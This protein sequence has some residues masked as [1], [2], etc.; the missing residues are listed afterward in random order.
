MKL[1]YGLNIFLGMFTRV[2][3]IF[4]LTLF[5]TIKQLNVNGD[6]TKQCKLE[7]IT[8]T[9]KH[10]HNHTQYENRNL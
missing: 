6:Q 2:K 8:K 7:N 1:N 9:V 10:I 3:H 4:P 5:T